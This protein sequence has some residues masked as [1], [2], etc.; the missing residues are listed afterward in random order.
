MFQA[1]RKE[2]EKGRIQKGICMCMIF[3]G[4]EDSEDIR[5]DGLRRKSLVN[6][7]IRTLIYVLSLEVEVSEL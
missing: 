1:S 3:L 5:S 4:M 2:E 6:G 7:V